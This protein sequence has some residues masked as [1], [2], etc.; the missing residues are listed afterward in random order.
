MKI[1]EK[2]D[3][4]PENCSGAI[5]TRKRSDSNRAPKNSCNQESNP[6]ASKNLQLIISEITTAEF[7]LAMQSENNTIF[8]IS[9]HE[10]NRDLDLRVDQSKDIEENLQGIHS[11]LPEF[12]KKQKL[13]RFTPK[14]G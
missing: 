8:T 1:F 10:I 11:K 12:L 4:A 7:H 9:L 13:L 6:S 5:T 2:I 3:A 14:L